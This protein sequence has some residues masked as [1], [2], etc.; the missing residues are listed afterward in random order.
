ME[1]IHGIFGGFKASETLIGIETYLFKIRYYADLLQSLRNPNRD[2]NCLWG[3]NIFLCGARWLQSL[4]NPNRDWNLFSPD[5]FFLFYGFK[6]S[7]TLIGIETHS[8]H[9][10]FIGSGKLQSLRNPNR[11]WNQSVT[12]WNSPIRSLQSLR[13]PNRDWNTI[14]SAKSIWIYCFKASETLIGIETPMLRIKLPI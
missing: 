14:R 3:S 12:V 1:V 6:A 13:N 11:D 9:S 7:E 8:G 2:W 5:G 4:R 10:Y